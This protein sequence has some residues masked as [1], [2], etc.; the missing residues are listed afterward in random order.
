LTGRKA[1]AVTTSVGAL[2]QEK[3]ALKKL[4]FFIKSL[5]AA[6]YFCYP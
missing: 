4:F 5:D 2:L 6:N 3:E 1:F